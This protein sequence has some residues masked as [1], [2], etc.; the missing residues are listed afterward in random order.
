[1]SRSIGL[2]IVATATHDSFSGETADKTMTGTSAIFGSIA[3]AA[4][5]S[6]PVITGI[7]RS[8]QNQSGRLNVSQ[9]LEPDTSV[10]C[11]IDI[12]AVETQKF[13]ECLTNGEIIL[14]EVYTLNC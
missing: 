4:R 6:H 7:M 11:L 2:L 12:V 5:N 3:L 14:D 1:M 10:G 8:Q 13:A 9:N